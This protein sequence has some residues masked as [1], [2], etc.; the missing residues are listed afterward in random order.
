MTFFKV[1]KDDQVV[2]VVSYAI[3]NRIEVHLYV[4]HNVKDINVKVLSLN[5]LI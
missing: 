2:D 4:E 3:G 5:I 1:N